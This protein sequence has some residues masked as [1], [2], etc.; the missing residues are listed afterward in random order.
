MV[1]EK[2]ILLLEK[3][4]GVIY[5]SVGTL[6]S[7][8]EYRSE[9][10]SQALLGTHV[11][12]FEERN[13]WL[14]VQTPDEYLGWM[15]G[16]VQ[17][18]TQSE[19]D[20]YFN[21]PKVIITSVFTGSYESADDKSLPVSD[22]VIGNILVLISE[23]NQFFKV[24]Y[25]DGRNAYIKQSDAKKY[26]EWL[27]SIELTGESIVNTA[28]KFLGVPYLWG[29][30]SA[31]G[32]DCSGFTKSVYLMHGITLPRDASQQVKQGQLVDSTGDYSKLITGDLVFFGTRILL[33][34][35]DEQENKNEKI[36]HVG[37][38]IGN[39]RFIHSSDNVHISSFN[40]DDSLYDE[41]NTN[42][43]LRTKRYIT[44]FE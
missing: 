1:K 20:H 37:I 38:Y 30:T 12:I 44:N 18:M 9:M 42:R 4:F 31:K 43:Y 29:G 15:K 34:N 5:N 25:P 7:A 17:L 39:S 23:E 2:N 36:V 24:A 33:L 19:L 40:P 22:L 13:G 3:N 10:V 32:L 27:D 41:Y 26:Q 16:S 6:R 21:K 8:P 35:E 28:Y 11:I 14:K